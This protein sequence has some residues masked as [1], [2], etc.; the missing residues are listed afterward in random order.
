MYN[1]LVSFLYQCTLPNPYS[2]LH[3]YL[4]SL[5]YWL[6]FDVY[7]RFH[8]PVMSIQPSQEVATLLLLLLCFAETLGLPLYNKLAPLSWL[9]NMRYLSSLEAAR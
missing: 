6:A 8:P 4:N 1:I 5:M 2:L 3:G 7:I 9:K